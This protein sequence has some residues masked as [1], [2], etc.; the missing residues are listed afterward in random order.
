MKK[1]IATI[2]VFIVLTIPTY[3]QEPCPGTGGTTIFYDASSEAN[4]Y[5]DVPLQ[6][7]GSYIAVKSNLAG[8]TLYYYPYLNG[9]RGERVAWATSGDWDIPAPIPQ[10][11]DQLQVYRAPQSSR[12]TQICL[13]GYAAPTNTATATATHT[14]TATPT[15]TATAT[16]TNTA[17]TTPTNTATATAT[18][19]PTPTVT[20]N[21]VLAEAITSTASTIVIITND[22]LGHWIALF[23]II[24]GAATIARLIWKIGQ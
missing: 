16:P 20:P 18:N 21:A 9:V 1:I 14:P 19:T 12:F 8:G 22:S 24:I 5:I 6:N 23:V 10:Q 7:A 11:F 3:A 4:A 2:I 15:N 13:Y 17:T